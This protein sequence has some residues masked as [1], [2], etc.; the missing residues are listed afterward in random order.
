MRYR[1]LGRTGLQVSEVG[2]GCGSVGGLMVRGEHA[3]QRAAVERALQLGIN[4]FDTA[5]SY[6]NGQSEQNL[7]QVLRELRAEPHIGTKVQVPTGAPDIGA[8]VVESVERSLKRLGRDSVDLIQLH[9]RVGADPRGGPNSLTPHQVLEDV[10]GA[11]EAL[12]AQGKVRFY[13]ITGMGETESVLEVLDAGAVY[14]VQTVYNLLN[15][16][17]GVPVPPSFYAQDFDGLIDRAADQQTGVIVIR[18]LAAGALA[19]EAERHPTA[20]GTSP[21]GSS[22]EY[23]DDVD[24][25]LRLRFLVDEGFAASP[26]DAALRFALSNPRVSVMLVGVSDREHVEQA[27]AAADRGPLP[28][29]ALDRL[30]RVWSEW[31]VV[32]PT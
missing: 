28:T 23:G 7:G 1:A 4:Y 8:A 15:P 31:T 13:G 5:A 30:A 24:R 12:R 22:T 10:V 9:S 11:F 20:G 21:M 17:A 6:G 18:A 19:G 27:V 25:A 32:P 14:S 2:F 3:E 16:S 29:E 26:V